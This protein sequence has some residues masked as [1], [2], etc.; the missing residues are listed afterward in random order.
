M[1][2]DGK[3]RIMCAWMDG[4]HETVFVEANNTSKPRNLAWPSSLSLDYVGR[5]LYWSDPLL[6]TIERIGLDGQNREVVLLSSSASMESTPYAIAYHMGYL[7]FTEFYPRKDGIK[8]LPV[9][10][11]KFEKLQLTR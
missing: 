2:N 3:P 1:H 8:K 7:Y 11:T 5:K 4:T 9:N 6:K 10:D